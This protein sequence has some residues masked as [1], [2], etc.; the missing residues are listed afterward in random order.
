MRFVFAMW[1]LDD[2]CD[3][4][5]THNGEMTMNAKQATG[6]RANS[7]DASGGP[8]CKVVAIVQALVLKRVEK[9]LEEIGVPGVSVTKVKG[10]GQYADFFRADWMTEH[11]R[12][13]I[14]LHGARVKEV[15]RA[16]I[17][18]ARTGGAG[19]GLVVVIPVETIYRIRSG[20]R[21]AVDDLGGRVRTSRN[22]LSEKTLEENHG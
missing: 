4:R 18:T 7:E 16:V 3:R 10:Y 5:T 17:A 11:A 19:D 22:E 8:F 21:A 2:E 12:I 20:R 15:V 6:R 14:F 9:R 1:T 13:E